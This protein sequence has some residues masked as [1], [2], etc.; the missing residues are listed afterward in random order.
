MDIKKYR[1]KGGKVVYCAKFEKDVAILVPE[2][3][4][5]ADIQKRTVRLSLKQLKDH[6]YEVQDTIT[7]KPSATGSGTLF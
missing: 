3:C 5:K 4:R 7:P 1:R 2:N 6:Y